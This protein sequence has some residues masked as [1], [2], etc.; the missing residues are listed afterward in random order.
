MYFYESHK[1]NKY[2]WGNTG[3][4]NNNFLELKNQQNM[5]K[6]VHELSNKRD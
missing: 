6:I 5:I 1:S 2:R 4:G 3:M